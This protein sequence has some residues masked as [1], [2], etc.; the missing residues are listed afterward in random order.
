[1]ASGMKLYS[2]ALAPNPRRVRIFAAEKGIELAVQDIDILAGQNRRPEFLAKNPSDGVPVLE[3]DDGSYLAESVAICRYL[4]G[5]HPEP[6]L[7]GRDLREQAQIEMWNRRMELELFAAI[8]RTVQNTS[9][10]F[11]GRSAACGRP[12][13]TR[14]DGSRAERTAVCRWRPFHDRRHHRAGRNRHRRP[15]N[16]FLQA[17]ASFLAGPSPSNRIPKLPANSRTF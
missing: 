3:L 4:E 5:L 13:T 14:T 11:Q 9:P 2:H 12:S 10:I 6:N 17:F 8:G 16:P 15:F 7:F 1:M